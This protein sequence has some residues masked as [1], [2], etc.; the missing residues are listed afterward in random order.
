M[1]ARVCIIC[2]CV[3]VNQMKKQHSNIAIRH[4]VLT[5]NLIIVN[6]HITDDVTGETALAYS[7][8]IKRALN[9]T[10]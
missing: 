6:C 7:E 4:G 8:M 5:S 2:V 10:R 3:S 9:R 1:K